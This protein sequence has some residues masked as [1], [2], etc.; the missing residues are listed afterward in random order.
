MAETLAAYPTL[1]R[2]EDSRRSSFISR[3]IA[4]MLLLSLG[5]HALV[6]LLVTTIHLP[7]V[8]RPSV[9]YEVSLVTLP[10]PEKAE[11][12]PV[13]QSAESA[14]PK[15]ALTLSGQAS[16]PP[17]APR[18]IQRPIERSALGKEQPAPAPMRQAST[19]IA[20]APSSPTQRSVKLPPPVPVIPLPKLS[21][22]RQQPTTSL[23]D[24]L[25]DVAL[26]PEVQPDSPSPT[27]PDVKVPL[28]T[29]AIPVPRSS[30]ESK[31]SPDDSMRN[32]LRDINLPPEAP[33]LA[34][35]TPPAGASSKQVPKDSSSVQKEI[36]SL[37][38]NLKVPDATA[39]PPKEAQV[40]SRP[41]PAR[42]SLSDELMKQVQKLQQAPIAAASPR[43][44]TEPPHPSVAMKTKPKTPVA[45]IQAQGGGPGFNQYLQVV[46]RKISQLWTPP[47]VDPN[48]QSL[49]VVI[50]FRLYRNGQVSEVVV[51]QTSGNEYYDLAGKRAVISARLP[52]F[53]DEMT[54]PYLDAH[55][56]FTVGE[57]AG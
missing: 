28:P 23:D 14:P 41:T 21:E 25:R 47:Q 37:L 27:R 55:F 16:N 9:T 38:S 51:E 32:L 48:V 34:E 52:E 46:Q 50:K 44:A 13:S 1:L 57:Q 54:M 4:A 43:S 17:V 26:P 39:L 2:L 6:L 36:Q 35:L 3:Q 10:T 56:S 31:Q 7:A 12:P 42:P 49:Q 22:V 18:V 15:P 20:P 5:L 24:I 19:P 33:K 8:E 45:A 11:T 30:S 29:S 53:P 40:P